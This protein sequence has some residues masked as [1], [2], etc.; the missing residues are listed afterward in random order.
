M[1]NVVTFLEDEDDPKLDISMNSNFHVIVLWCDDG[2]GSPMYGIGIGNVKET[3]LRAARLALAASWNAW[4]K[5]GWG[6]PVCGDNQQM[7]RG[8]YDRDP[9]VL[10]LLDL[11]LCARG[12]TR[13]I[14]QRIGL[15][16]PSHC[17]SAERT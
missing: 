8:L 12:T 4:G 5:L 9:Q 6:R 3:R 1:K 2:V 10:T 11:V 13:N 15:G 16:S 7:V 14:V 17:T